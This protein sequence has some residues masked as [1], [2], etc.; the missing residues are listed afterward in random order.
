MH[1][2][3]FGL[4]MLKPARAMIT[5]KSE[6]DMVNISVDDNVE[7]AVL[8]AALASRGLA[9]VWRDGHPTIA[10]AQA[11]SG[12]FCQCGKVAQILVDGRT[13]C[14]SCYLGSAC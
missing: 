4:S 3:G 5:L 11:E 6:H 1:I 7:A 9:M 14:A 13:F 8:S 12:P 2:L 10:K